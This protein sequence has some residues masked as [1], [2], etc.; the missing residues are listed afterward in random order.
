VSNVPQLWLRCGDGDNYTNYDQDFSAA[1]LAA[2][3]MGVR[4]PLSWLP[5]PRSGGFTC[6]GFEGRNYVSLY[7]GTAS[8]D[9]VEQLDTDERKQFESEIDEL[10]EEFGKD[11]S[12]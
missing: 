9:Y 5:G 2:F 7:W 12:V 11:A 3:E 10:V 8:A 6:G 1:A 4:K